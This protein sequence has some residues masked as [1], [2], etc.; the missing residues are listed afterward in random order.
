MSAQ[1]LCSYSSQ[2]TSCIYV[3]IMFVQGLCSRPPWRQAWECRVKDCGEAQA[4]PHALAAPCC[5]RWRQLHSRCACLCAIVHMHAFV[6]VCV[7]TCVCVCVCVFL[8]LVGR[9]LSLTPSLPRT[10]RA[11][12]NITAVL[13]VECVVCARTCACMC[14]LEMQA[15]PHTFT[16]PCCACR[17]ITS[18]QAGGG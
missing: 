2:N 9:K 13:L 5:A 16:T 7:R 6:L 15:V 11:G 17:Q 8:C 12:V 10:M 14:A 4:L 1:G 18:Q 3:Y